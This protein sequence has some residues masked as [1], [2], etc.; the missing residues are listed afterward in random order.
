MKQNGEDKKAHT[1]D[2]VMGMREIPKNFNIYIAKKKKGHRKV[3]S[4]E[5]QCNKV[6]WKQVY[7][8]NHNDN[9]KTVTF[10]R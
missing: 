6:Q 5:T 4:A 2:S 1:A 8:I 7:K 3:V 10:F 9:D